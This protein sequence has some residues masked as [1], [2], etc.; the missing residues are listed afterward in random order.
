ML[1]V[2]AADVNLMSNILKFE[3]KKLVLV[4]V[5]LPLVAFLLC[6]LI[7]LLK[8]FEEVNNTHCKVKKVVPKNKK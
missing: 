1:S 5:S 6:V 4:V 7:S 3:I 2:A 8:D